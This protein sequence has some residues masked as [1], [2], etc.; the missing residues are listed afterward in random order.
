MPASLKENASLRVLMTADAVGGVWQYALDLVEGLRPHGV[1]TTLAVLGPAPTADQRTM[2]D[3]AGAKLILTE[4]PL[5]WTAENQGEVEEAGRAIARIAEQIRP[6]LVHLN[7]P[8]LGA[9]ARFEAPV[10]AVCHSCV[11]TWWQA[12]RGGALPEEF[13]WRTDLVRQGYASAD[14]LLAPTAA[15]ARAT[16]EA[17]GL[18]EAPA[19]VRNGRRS[20]ASQADASS[21]PFVF[22]AGR[23]WDEGKN[24]A[25]I[26]H[27]AARLPVPVLAAGPL[28]GPNGTQVEARNAKTLGRLSDGEIA[29]KLSARPIFVSVARYEPFGL[30]V[31]EAAQAGCPLVLSDIPTFRELWEG[32][33]LFVHPDDEDTLADAVNRLVQDAEARDRLGRAARERAVAYS[34]EAMSAGVLSAYR[35]LLAQPSQ[36]SSLEGAAA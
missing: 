30:A 29:R 26:D 31:L 25:A 18:S 16:A 32:A 13:V 5:D 11:A 7:S 2:A 27:A 15:F 23:L 3:A 4:L 34:L 1:E 21:E 9:A 22:T 36:R 20:L 19:V 8:A 17:Y 10:V 24:F 12:V 28:Q 33:A 14:R 35:F 6:D